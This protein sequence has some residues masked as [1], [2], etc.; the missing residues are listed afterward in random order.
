VVVVVVPSLQVVVAGAVESAARAG[1]AINN[2]NTGAATNP[3]KFANLIIR[4]LV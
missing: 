4:S 3:A 2:T 1:S